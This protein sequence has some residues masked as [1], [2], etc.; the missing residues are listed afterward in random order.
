MRCLSKKETAPKSVADRIALLG[1]N[2]L[3][4]THEPDPA[5]KMLKDIQNYNSI[6]E[7]ITEQQLQAREREANRLIRERELNKVLLQHSAQSSGPAASN[8]M[9]ELQ[10][11]LMNPE[12]AQV[13]A[14]MTPE[15]QQMQLNMM[16]MSS[17][18]GGGRGDNMWPMIF[19]MLQKQ[20]GG[21]GIKMSDILAMNT[22]T[23]KQTM[24][25]IRSQMPQRSALSDIESIAKIAELLKGEK[26]GSLQDTV[27]NALINK[28]LNKDENNVESLV[29]TM[30][31]L[32]SA[33]GGS[34]S[35]EHDLAIA[36]LNANTQLQIMNMNA[37]LARD[38][39]TA[40][41][42]QLRTQQMGNLANTAIAAAAPALGQYVS[43]FAQKVAQQAA[44]QENMGPQP[45]P[46][47]A[48]QAQP[49][50]HSQQWASVE[51][52]AEGCHKS[53]E[54]PLKPDGSLPD[55]VKCPHCG[56]VLGV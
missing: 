24:E 17:F 31:T 16:M 19:M 4:T 56:S 45:Q 53:F 48:L 42:E 14:T 41:Q 2:V 36:E 23:M 7:L 38:R 11:A 32:Q 43:G 12:F 37:Q 44:Q 20:G 10:K 40:R 29:K 22:E 6:N 13:W 33:F 39:E 15:Q 30:G 18:S 46:T 1:P 49:Q 35:T 55:R 3:G 9:A 28:A 21:E 50:A 26:G 47:P 51:C 52:G 54:V 8:A 27:V 5:L 25:I 34:G